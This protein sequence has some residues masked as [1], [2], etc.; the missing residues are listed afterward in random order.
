LSG[1]GEGSRFYEASGEG[2]PPK[3]LTILRRPRNRTYNSVRQLKTVK[4][5][6]QAPIHASKLVISILST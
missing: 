4:K 3:I 5:N 2:G 1:I 6:I